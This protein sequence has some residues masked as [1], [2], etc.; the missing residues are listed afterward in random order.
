M[1]AL[2]ELENVSASYGSV[3]ALWGVDLE[4][5]QG[6]I[7]ALLGANGAGKTT[8][9]RTIVGLLRPSDGDIRINGKSVVGLPPHKVARLGVG[10]APEGRRIFPNLTVGENLLMGG[11]RHSN[12]GDVRRLRSR[13]LKLFPILEEKLRQR[14]SDL[15]GGEQQMLAIGR[16]LMADP[17]I[18]LLD[19]PSL[20]LSP[21]ASR[22]IFRTIRELADSGVTI[23]LI[24]QNV[25]QAARI[26]GQVH[27]L[28]GGRIVHSSSGTEVLSEDAVKQAFL[29]GRQPTVRRRVSPESED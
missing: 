26:S 4:V 13:A 1:A 24:E 8:T 16:A 20:G 14:G 7:V 12:D 11:Y 25:R 3:R 22:V 21:I 28:Q 29:G 2:L 5:E 6:K 19:E 10:V 27:V 17:Q 15:S 9:V 23:L 18:L